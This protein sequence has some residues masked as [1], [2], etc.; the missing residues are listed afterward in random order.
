MRSGMEFA[1]ICLSVI[2]PGFGQSPP[3]PSSSS[4]QTVSRAALPSG[5]FVPAP[6]GPYPAGSNPPLQQTGDF[7]GDSIPDLAIGDNINGTVSILLGTGNGGFS[8]APKSPFPIGAGALQMAAGDFD[9]DGK[10][11]LI[12]VLVPASNISTVSVLLSDGLGGFTTSFQKNIQ[13]LQPSAILATDLNGDGVPDVAVADLINLTVL[14]GDGAG[15][16]SLGTGGGSAF[17]L[18][19]QPSGIAVADFNLDGKVDLAISNFNAGNVTVVLGDGFGGFAQASGS[20]YGGFIGPNAVV[21]GDF[22]G[23]GKPDIAVSGPAS[24]ALAVLIGDGAGGF[25]AAPPSPIAAGTIVIGM[26]AADFNGDGIFDLALI[27]E[28]RGPAVCLGAG[29]GTFQVTDL[30]SIPNS[31][32]VS[33]AIAADFNGDGRLDLSAGNLTGSSGY[34]IVVFLGASAATST[35]LTATAPSSSSPNSFLLR[36]AI[37]PAPAFTAAQGNVRFFDGSFLLGT[38]A[39]WNGEATLLVPLSPGSH[40]LSARYDG[41][42]R[43]LPST[44]KVVNLGITSGPLLPHTLSIASIADRPFS[45]TAFQLF[46]N[47]D[48]PAAFLSG[49]PIVFS[50]VSGPATVQGNFLT[51]TGAGTVTIQASQDGNAQYL[52]ATPVTTSFTITAASQTI[53]W[54][55]PNTA[56]Y[57]TTPFALLA[58]ASSGLPVSFAVVSGPITLDGILATTSGT[59]PAVIRISQPGNANYLPADPVLLNITIS[60]ATQTITFAALPDHNISDAPFRIS[61]TASSGL[62]V[63]YQISGPASISRDLLTITGPGFVSVTASQ[64]G[65][66]VYLS[67]QPV[68]QSFR[69]FQAGVRVDAVRNAASYYS[70]AVGSYAVIFG[71]QLATQ[72]VAATGAASSQLGGTTVTFTGPGVQKTAADLYYVSPTQINLIVPPALP[73]GNTMVVVA[74]SS[75]TSAPFVFTLPQVTPGIFTSNGSGTGALAGYATIVR[76]DGSVTTLPTFQCTASPAGCTPAPIPVGPKGAKVYLTL[77]GTGIRNLSGLAGVTATLGGVPGTVVYAGPQGNYPALDQINLLVDP[78][79]GPRLVDLQVTVDEYASNS[80]QVQFQ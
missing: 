8:A 44:S 58:S 27:D 28:H 53:T 23:D 41:D 80:V 68:T 38:T 56:T 15:G 30:F 21:A 55:T 10:T 18:L 33:R 69:V 61:A 25:V 64:A 51:P 34:Q 72:T 26:I 78:Y 16:L 6:G 57:S 32:L 7:N 66:A 75:G 70:S 11:D 76:P 4:H 48:P 79:T 65:N 22:N 71:N 46:A 37:N 35:T 14:I 43:T 24:I 73:P 9:G 29:D 62:P 42:E 40:A 50:V 13:F 47:S 3:D 49:I 45:K 74:N 59:G 77:Y 31:V 17:R 52:A 36:A 5:S 2:I 39:A 1:A 54:S 63:S 19:N 60:D 12:I 20:P 67:A